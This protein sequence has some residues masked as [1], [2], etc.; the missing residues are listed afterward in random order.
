M[1]VLLIDVNCKFSSTGKISYDLF[2]ELNS[3]NHIASV[4]YG[5]GP[6][7]NEP[8]IIKYGYDLET[9]FHAIMTRITGLTGYF[10]VFSTRRLIRHIIEFQPDIVHLQDLHGYHVN[11][12]KVV[13]YLKKTNIRT[14]WTFQ[15]EFNY[16]GKCGHA[17]DCRG[18]EENCGNC[19]LLR[20]YPK[21][22]LIDF[23]RFM[24]KQKKEWFKD[25]SNLV[26]IAPSKWVK[27]RIEK[28]F[29]RDFSV[30]II[31]NGIDISVFNKDYS[32]RQFE[33]YRTQFSKFILNIIPNL[34]DAEKGFKWV[35]DL[36][37]EEKLRN[38]LFIVVTK[39]VKKSTLK[40]NLL[41][42][43]Y[44]NNQ[45]ELAKIYSSVDL[46]LVTSKYES[47]SMISLEAIACGLSVAGFSVG[48]I[49]DAIQGNDKFMVDYGS[50][51]I[52]NKILEALFDS[53]TELNL[54]Y[55]KI[56]RLRML[57]EYINV[58]EN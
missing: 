50:P 20:E 26:I 41:F 9:I 38:F 30:S 3:Q 48:G 22:L 5:R 51:D 14:V 39:G 44:K 10:S 27:Y 17:K 42:I 31:E 57:K 28:S 33:N 4:A 55:Y 25:W 1:K 43:P 23:T 13:S 6:K 36:S 34:Y 40:N 29:L 12:G 52:I 45:T 16:T 8:R 24:L 58:Y 47:Y 11:I 32:D 35:Q 49:P 19:P 15:S 46:F 53:G 37:N 7:I 56:S 54:D 18:F 2:T 21:S